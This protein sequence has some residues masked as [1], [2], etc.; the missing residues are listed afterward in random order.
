MENDDFGTRFEGP[1]KLFKLDF[2]NKSDKYEIIF[3]Q[4]P[5]CVVTQLLKYWQ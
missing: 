2:K 4:E 1:C 3:W 5:H